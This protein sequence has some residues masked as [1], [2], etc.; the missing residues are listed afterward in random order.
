MIILK[1]KNNKYNNFFKN[2][3]AFSL[4]EV[5]LYTAILSVFLLSMTS[6]INSVIQ[7]KAKNRIIL[8][9]ERQGEYISSII[10][11]KIKNSQSINYPISS[12]NNSLS[13]NTND[14]NLNPTVISIV[15]DKISIKEGTAPVVYLNSDNIIAENLVFTENSFSASPENISATFTLRTD[16]MSNRAEFNYDQDYFVNI[17]R[18][19]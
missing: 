9:V 2:K 8:D 7:A 18:R 19:Y 17:S 16:S 10:Y 13:L 4:V 14:S 3:K 6:F 1:A 5:M 12:S 15:D 11:E